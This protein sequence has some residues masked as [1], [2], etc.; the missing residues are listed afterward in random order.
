MSRVLALGAVDRNFSGRRNKTVNREI[1]IGPTAIKFI[2][3]AICAILALIYLTQATAGANRSVKVRDLDNKQAQLELERERLEA[4][5]ARFKS[6][7]AV[8]QGAEA[9]GLQQVPGV[10]HLN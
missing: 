3:I 4:E 8:K 7:E 6:L 10:E 5:Q 1:T 2:T 9:A